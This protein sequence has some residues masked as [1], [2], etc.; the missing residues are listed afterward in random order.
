MLCDALRCMLLV[1]AH[2]SV[3]DRGTGTLAQGRFRR[4][5]AARPAAKPAATEVDPGAGTR[6]LG[7]ETPAPNRHSERIVPEEMH[8]EN[9]D[10]FE[11][12]REDE[13]LRP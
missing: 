2:Y 4:S 9:S 5:R 7:S 10:D 11:D 12:T 6:A 1:L 13:Q 8:E 3:V